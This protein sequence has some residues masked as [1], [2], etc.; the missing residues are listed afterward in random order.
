MSSSSIP[1]T[2]NVYGYITCGDRIFTVKDTISLLFNLNNNQVN[3]E[4]GVLNIHSAHMDIEIK[5]KDSSKW[6][7]N[8]AIAGEPDTIYS[9][10]KNLAQHLSWRRIS[11]TYEIYNDEFECINE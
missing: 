4:G 9:I 11:S 6:S 2:Y 7:F 5:R 1:G 8:A 10:V 3:F